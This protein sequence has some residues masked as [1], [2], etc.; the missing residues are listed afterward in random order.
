MLSGL[1]VPQIS[2][3][4]SPAHIKAQLAPA[5]NALASSYVEWDGGTSGVSSVFFLDNPGLVDGGEWTRY[6]QLITSDYSQFALFGVDKCND[7]LGCYC[8]TFGR[9]AYYVFTD[10]GGDNA[11]V[12]SEITGNPNINEQCVFTITDNSTNNGVE[13]Q[14]SCPYDDTSFPCNGGGCS[15]Y[16]SLPAWFRIQLDEYIDNTF[17]GHNVWGGSW[18]DNKWRSVSTGAWNFQSRNTD[19]RN[20]GNPPQMYWHQ[21]P[22]PGNAGGILYSCDYDS[23]TTCNYRS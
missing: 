21:V 2:A 22:A 3:A 7:N 18:T 15:E 13:F 14:S 17:T 19:F 16:F 23:G 10:F 9:S 8:P 20:A 5:I 1:R 12:C 11:P 6:I 4:A